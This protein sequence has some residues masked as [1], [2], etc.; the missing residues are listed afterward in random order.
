MVREADEELSPFRAGM[1]P[2]AFT[3][4]RHAAVDRLVRDRLG[5]P[6]ISFT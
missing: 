3:R 5:L 4:A 6:T 1:P 2:D